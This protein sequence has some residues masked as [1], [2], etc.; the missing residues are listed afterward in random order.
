MVSSQLATI[1]IIIRDCGIPQ[2][3]AIQQQS[4]LFIQLNEYE[5]VDRGPKPTLE[6]YLNSRTATAQ[7]EVYVLKKYVEKNTPEKAKKFH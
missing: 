7:E 4:A 3:G 1:T 5:K 6:I 2:L